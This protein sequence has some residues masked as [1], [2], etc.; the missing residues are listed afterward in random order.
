MTNVIQISALILA[1]AQV[2]SGGNV[3]AVSPDKLCVGCLQLTQTFVKD[4]NR[5]IG[6]QRWAMADRLS[7]RESFAMA[8]LWLRH[9]IREDMDVRD[10]ALVFKVGPTHWREKTGLNSWTAA[11]KDYAERAAA[12]Y[13]DITKGEAAK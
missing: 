7:K 12:I 2:E 13:D 3:W 8:R 1:L 4:C 10:A 11:E 9:Y 5:Q 6:K